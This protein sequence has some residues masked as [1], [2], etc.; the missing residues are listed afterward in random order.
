MKRLVDV[1]LDRQQ[2]IDPPLALLVLVVT[3]VL[4]GKQGLDFRRQC[5]D[6]ER[7]HSAEVKEA[8]KIRKSVYSILRQE[9]REQHPAGRRIWSDNGQG[10]GDSHRPLFWAFI[11]LII[12]ATE[13]KTV[14]RRCSEIL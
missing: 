1:P 6:G 13:Y 7:C 5:V 2:F 11:N 12:P 4:L 10:G 3:G 9:Q 8:E 14:F